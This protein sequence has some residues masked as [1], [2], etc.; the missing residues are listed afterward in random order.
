MKLFRDVIKMKVSVIIPVYNNAGE[1]V[2]AIN[3]ALGQQLSPHE[4]IVVDDGSDDGTYDAVKDF[5]DKVVLLKQERKRQS[6][7]RNRAVKEASGDWLAL[8]DSDDIWFP[9]KLLELQKTILENPSVAIVHSDAWVIEGSK[10][11]LNLSDVPTY[12]SDKTPPCGNEAFVKHLSTPLVTSTVLIRRDA[13]LKAG[14]FDESL[15]VCEDADLFLRIMGMGFE[16]A[17]CAKPLIIQRCHPDGMGRD[18]FGY[19][20]ASIKVLQ[21]AVKEFPAH[22]KIL[23]ESLAATSRVAVLYALREKKYSDLRKYWGKYLK[24]GSPSFKDIIPSVL[25]FIPGSW[26][27]KRLSKRWSSVI[28]R[29]R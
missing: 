14:G 18:Q 15:K 25:I 21:K 2:E 11:P 28:S 3:S 24:N 5:G 4:I 27:P 22:K 17:Y 23:G 12:F 7:A 6:A 19:L 16:M 26:G 20:N 10:P 1:V 9:G 8:L 29:L 13:F